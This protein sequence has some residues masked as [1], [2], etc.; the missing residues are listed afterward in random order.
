ML[1]ARYLASLKEKPK[2]RR[3]FFRVSRNTQRKPLSL[4]ENAVAYVTVR[5]APFDIEL[6]AVA[7]SYRELDFTR[8]VAKVTEIGE[9][10]DFPPLGNVLLAHSAKQQGVTFKKG[11][12]LSTL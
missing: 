1:R 4:K 10:G 12:P 5:D 6:A 3:W 8:L 11:V 2:R 7:S 9:G